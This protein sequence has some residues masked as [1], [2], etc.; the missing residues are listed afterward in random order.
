[1][2]LGLCLPYE[3]KIGM[4]LDMQKKDKRKVRILI[5][6]FTFFVLT[7]V[8]FSLWNFIL[9]EEMKTSKME[10]EV[11]EKDIKKIESLER[12]DRIL[13]KDVLRQKAIEA[14]FLELIGEHKKKYNSKEI[15]NCI[16][17]IAMIDEKSRHKE[18]DAPLVFAW[19]EK[20]S[21][22]NPTAVSFM[23][24]KGLTQLMDFRAKEAFVN[25]GY[26]DYEKELVFDPVINL[27]GG[28]NHFFELMNYWR[29]NGIKNE[30][31]ILF[32]AL[33]SYKWGTGNTEQ[34][35][36]S[37]KREYRPSIEYINWI[38]NRKEYWSEK[39]ENWMNNPQ[40]SERGIES[41][42]GTTLLD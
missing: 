14:C 30:Y 18:L 23:G 16:Q 5:S 28:L 40:R 20:E 17:L 6:I 36:N 39:L 26:S 33:H 3:G 1:M 19:L 29:R 32:Y 38:L 42:S 7:L 35:F 11:L 27:T 41:S 10:R 31:L 9:V 22:G 12:T 15:Q 21:D 37:E 34:L 8:L 4:D 13:I 24:A 25:L 2:N